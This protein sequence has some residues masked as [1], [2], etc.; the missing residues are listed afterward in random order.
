MNKMIFYRK[1]GVMFG[2]M[3]EQGITGHSE[4]IDDLHAIIEI[5]FHFE[6]MSKMLEE[7]K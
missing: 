5:Y 4:Q 7:D 3:P 2:T 1:D 6:Y